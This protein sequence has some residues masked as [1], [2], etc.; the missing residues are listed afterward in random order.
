MLS[1]I[2]PDLSIKGPSKWHVKIGIN[3]SYESKALEINHLEF[4]TI[5]STL[6]YLH[7]GRSARLASQIAR[8]RRFT[9]VKR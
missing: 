6:R 2:L 9:Q 1:M 4:D 3:E 7:V 5:K 8:G